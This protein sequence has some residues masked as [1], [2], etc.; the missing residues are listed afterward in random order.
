[1]STEIIVLV[2]ALIS[3]VTALV[4]LT[5]VV[6][7]TSNTVSTELQVVHKLINSRMDEQLELVRQLA[8]AQ[9]VK[10]QKSENNTRGS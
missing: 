3:L 2:T 1:M 10:D 6:I 9:G 7:R 5:A 8:H 4:A